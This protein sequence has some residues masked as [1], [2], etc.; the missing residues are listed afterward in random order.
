MPRLLRRF[1]E[2]TLREF[3]MSRFSHSRILLVELVL[4]VVG[5]SFVW[6]FLRKAKKKSVD[7]PF[8]MHNT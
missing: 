5:F 3:H 2:A 4:V 1:F 8:A 6:V 7:A